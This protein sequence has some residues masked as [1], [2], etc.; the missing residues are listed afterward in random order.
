MI[1]LQCS[2][3]MLPVSD[4]TTPWAYA[5]RERGVLNWLNLSLA[6]GRARTTQCIRWRQRSFKVSRFY[7]AFGPWGSTLHS[8]HSSRQ[9]VLWKNF[10]FIERE[11]VGNKN[12]RQVQRTRHVLLWSLCTTSRAHDLTWIGV[13][14]G[15]QEISERDV[16]MQSVVDTVENE[17]S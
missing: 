16:L 17:C 5:H 4:K 3:L 7:W 2:F 11:E 9:N 14:P 10:N 6:L 12:W 8:I 13:W 15:Q 1:T